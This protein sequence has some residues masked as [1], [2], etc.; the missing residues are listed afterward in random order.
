MGRRND[1]LPVAKT[2]VGLRIDIPPPVRD[3]LRDLATLHGY[4]MAAFLKLLI[5]ATIREPGWA[6]KKIPKNRET[7]LDTPTTAR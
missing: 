2:D 5:V 1:A 3:D 4:S 7:S 6:K